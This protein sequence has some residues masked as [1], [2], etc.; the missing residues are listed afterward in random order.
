MVKLRQIEEAMAEEGTVIEVTLSKL[1]KDSTCM[2]MIMLPPG[3][4]LRF[5]HAT[6]TLVQLVKLLER[7]WHLFR[8]RITFHFNS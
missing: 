1:S 6:Q 3:N 4:I 5:W 2:M 8:I 7:K